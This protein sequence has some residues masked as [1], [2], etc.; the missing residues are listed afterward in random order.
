MTTSTLN[1]LSHA[2]KKGA[3]KPGQRVLLRVDLNV[4]MARGEVI[5]NTRVISVADTINALVKKKAKVILLSHFGRPNGTFSMD[6]SLAP[7][8]DAV[9]AA[10]NGQ[11]VAFGVDCIGP[12]A[13]AAVDSLK[14]GQVLLLE[15]LRFHKGE[16]ANSAAFVKK[17]AALGDV[18]VNDA[19][20]CAHRTHASIVGLPK[21]LPAY[22]GL[23]FE[24]ELS[25]LDALLG[26]PKEPVAAII[27][28]AKVSTKLALLESLAAKMEHLLI[29]GGMANTFL[30]AQD[31]TVGK[32]L[33]EK[34][35]TQE[36]IHILAV[37]KR[38]NCTIHLPS[39]VIVTKELAEH[40][41]NSMV[42]TSTVSP[43]DMIVDIGLNTMAEW[44]DVLKGCKTVVWNGPIGAFEYSPFDVSTISLARFIAHA[45]HHGDLRS[46]AGGGDMLGALARAG[47]QESFT[48]ISTAG[49]AFLEW[50]EGKTLPGVA[51]LSK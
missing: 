40:H 12:E 3:I 36:A 25:H 17:L 11:E 27:G 35:L 18:Y 37:A 9:S 30:F 48:Y 5:D 31:Y 10:L 50:L 8:A 29:G 41:V 28:G 24:K 23:L 4:P 46:V 13:E 1:T 15:N 14:N 42:E 43:R 7:I 47:L 20:A 6:Y 39:D 22:A 44:M 34:E 45:T 32:S 33:C 26:T 49:G 21:Y 2:L 38:H 51:A 16:E 19:F